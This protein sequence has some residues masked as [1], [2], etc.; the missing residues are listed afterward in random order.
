MTLRVH[1]EGGMMKVVG[2]A[3]G[4]RSESFPIVGV[5]IGPCAEPPLVYSNT[6][7][8]V[9]SAVQKRLIEKARPCTFTD[10]DKK[11][12]FGFAQKACHGKNAIFTKEKVQK[13]IATHSDF[14]TLK[15]GKWSK[16]RLESSL[17][18]LYKRC[19]VDFRLSAAIKAEV[20]PTGKPPRLLI[21]DGDDGQLM[22]VLV[23]KCFEELLFDH[24]EKKSI[25]HCG[26]REAVGRCVGELIPPRNRRDDSGAI[27][28]DGSAW[29]T[30]CNST[31]RGSENYIL[32]HIMVCML[33]LGFAPSEWHEAHQRINERANLKIFY[34]GKGKAMG[35]K[36]A[37]IRRSGH[38]GTSC[39]NWW[40]NYSMWYCSVFKDPTKFLDA[41]TRWGEDIRGNRRW[42]NGCFEG[43]DS[44]I[45]TSPK[46]VEGS[47]IANDVLDFWRRAG[48]DMK[49]V[50][51]DDR[52]TFVGWHIAAVRGVL[53]ET[54]RTPELPRAMKTS[55][56]CSSSAVK[57]ARE[58]NVA[59]AK[60]VGAAAC[61]ARAADFAG[62]LPTVSK[63]YLDYADTLM[64]KGEEFYDREL[65]MRVLGFEDEKVTT[66]TVRDEIERL[67]LGA[68]P[69]VE[70]V[71]LSGLR[72]FAEDEEL[73]RFRDYQWSWE[74]L[75]DYD[76]FRG[77]LPQSWR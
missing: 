55:V 75:G 39:L 3:F 9:Q 23:V 69:D 63:K 60:Q 43:D 58:D 71:W 45:S 15:S 26:K 33:E 12:F 16:E 34:K 38:R 1:G 57:A 44:L 22:A 17:D 37:A 20:M 70:K 19:H 32:D 51:V 10:T 72:Y 2:R 6:F 50:F 21:A 36:I 64:V 27:E 28:G 74:N 54:I 62:L 14:E 4:D 53:H 59:V 76:G 40:T 61:I 66:S 35:I 77:S 67:N 65:S 25:K 8:N 48:F 24:F 5:Q 73:S 56:S 41:E 18:A 46:L 11:K 49:I 47:D 68:D 13:W 7:E 42:F 31:V 52:A 30:T 29:D